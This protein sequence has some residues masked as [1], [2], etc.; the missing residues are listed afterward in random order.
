M[1]SIVKVRIFI[2]INLQYI[3]HKNVHR[4]ITLLLL[5]FSAKSARMFYRPHKTVLCDICDEDD[6]GNGCFKE[7]VTEES[8]F[9]SSSAEG[10]IANLHLLSIAATLIWMIL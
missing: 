2:T 7:T 9:K 1:T 4:N 6:C 5:L 8:E 3:F 10:F